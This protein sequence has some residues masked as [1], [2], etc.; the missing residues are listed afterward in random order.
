MGRQLMASGKRFQNDR[1]LFFDFRNGSESLLCDV[2]VVLNMAAFLCYCVV[3]GDGFASKYKP[4]FSWEMAKEF[5][6]CSVDIIRLFFGFLSMQLL[7]CNFGH[8]TRTELIKR[9]KILLNNKQLI[10]TQQEI[11]ST[12]YLMQTKINYIQAMQNLFPQGDQGHYC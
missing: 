9:N 8:N 2:T 6:C 10:S 7:A 3:L 4:Y 11:W 5:A 12:Q 1:A